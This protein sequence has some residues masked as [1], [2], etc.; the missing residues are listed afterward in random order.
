MELNQVYSVP[1]MAKILRINVEALYDLIRT[2]DFPYVKLYERGEIRICGWQ[3][4]EW[5]DA[6]CR[7]IPVS[8]EETA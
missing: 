6:H 5:L 8:R 4:K 3:V 2:K 1:E 7:N